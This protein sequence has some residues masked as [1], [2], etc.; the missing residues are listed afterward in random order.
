MHTTFK[1]K[2]FTAFCVAFTGTVLGSFFWAALGAGVSHLT[3]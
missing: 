1:Q 2:L 3:H